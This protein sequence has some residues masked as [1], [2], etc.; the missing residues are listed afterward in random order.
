[1]V[2]DKCLAAGHRRV[3]HM[4]GGFAAWKKAG[5]PYIATNPATGGPMD[6]R[7]AV[8]SAA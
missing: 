1:M 7:D 2:A 6:R 8:A 5:Q 4:A 3:I